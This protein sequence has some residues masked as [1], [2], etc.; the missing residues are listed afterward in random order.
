[1]VVVRPSAPKSIAW[2]LAN[3]TRSNPMVRRRGDCVSAANT[4]RGEGRDAT[5]RARLASS[6]FTSRFV[7]PTVAVWTRSRAFDEAPSR[8]V[9]DVAQVSAMET[10]P[11]DG[12]S[13]GG[14]L[15]AAGSER[16][17]QPSKTVKLRIRK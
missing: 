12:R 5:S 2:L 10:G 11:V 4:Q 8:F 7:R 16:H 6:R 14:T 1:M 13:S 17:D 15:P 3:E 9:N